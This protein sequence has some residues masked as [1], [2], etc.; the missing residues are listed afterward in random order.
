MFKHI[1]VIIIME[2]SFKNPFEVDEEHLEMIALEE[3]RI[4]HPSVSNEPSPSASVQPPSNSSMFDLLE[5]KI[6][7]ETR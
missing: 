2:D 4:T 5:S 3:N 1:I 6:E 7:E